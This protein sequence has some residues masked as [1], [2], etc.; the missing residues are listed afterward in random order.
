MLAS[1]VTGRRMCLV[2]WGFSVCSTDV[3]SYA[4]AK[5]PLGVLRRSMCSGG[6]RAPA[7]SELCEPYELWRER[8]CAYRWGSGCWARVRASKA[9]ALRRS[10]G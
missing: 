8:G 9:E 7:A 6:F 3:P 2:A 5:M 1:A 4:A 10:G